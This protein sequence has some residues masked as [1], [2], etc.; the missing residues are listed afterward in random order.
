FSMNAL[1]H[2]LFSGTRTCVRLIVSPGVITYS[3]IK[4]RIDTLEK[5]PEVHVIFHNTRDTVRF[6][7]LAELCMNCYRFR[8]TLLTDNAAVIVTDFAALLFAEN[9]ALLFTDYTLTN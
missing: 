4:H 1:P 8:S 6:T 9:V 7:L 3:P 2:R 5:G